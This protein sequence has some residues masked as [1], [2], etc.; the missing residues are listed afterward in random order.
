MVAVH[1]F[2]HAA[3]Q[4]AARDALMAQLRDAGATD[5]SRAATLELS[6]EDSAR[7]LGELLEAGLVRESVTGLYYIEPRPPAAIPERNWGFA[8]LLVLLVL[9]SFGVSAAMLIARP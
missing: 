4:Q 8:L 6:S 5:A 9:A 3:Q 1:M 7:A 2:I